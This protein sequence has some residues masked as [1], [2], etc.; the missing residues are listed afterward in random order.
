MA[1]KIRQ[2]LKM[3]VTRVRRSAKNVPIL[4]RDSH[5]KMMGDLRQEIKGLKE[6]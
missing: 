4:S 6:H 2:A 1:I 3:V 5:D